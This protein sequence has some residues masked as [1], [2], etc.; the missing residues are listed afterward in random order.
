MDFGYGAE[1]AGGRG[2]SG[3]DDF[4][5]ESAG[6]VGKAAIRSPGSDNEIVIRCVPGE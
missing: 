2:E 5:W 3:P 6:F 4:R 1:I